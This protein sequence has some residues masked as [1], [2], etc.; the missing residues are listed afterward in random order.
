MRT[1]RGA[2]IAMI[3]QDPMTSLH[4]FYTVGDQIAEAIRQHQDVSKKEA[5]DRAVEMLGHVEHP[6]AATSAPSSTRTSS[7]A[8]CASAR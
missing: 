6:A 7:P 2:K 4:P 1:I 8:A 3:F 5:C